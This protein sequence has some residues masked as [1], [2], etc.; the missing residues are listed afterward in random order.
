MT[1][2][3][4]NMWV[5]STHRN[6]MISDEAMLQSKIRALSGA[7]RELAESG[8][9]V[10]LNDEFI[11]DMHYM[12]AINLI[13]DIVDLAKRM[14]EAGKLVDTTKTPWGQDVLATPVGLI[15]L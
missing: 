6:N 14:I 9:D 7:K 12:R 15:A 5:N 13:N 2:M 1:N 10:V 4:K 8:K 11:I 3:T